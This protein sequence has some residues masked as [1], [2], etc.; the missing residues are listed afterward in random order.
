[1]ANWD[2]FH[3]DRL[4]LERNLTSEEIRQAV[5]KGD[6][7]DDDLVRPAGTTIAWARL[8]DYPDL[9]TASARLPEPPPAPV[10]IP[11]PVTDIPISLD[12]K[13][14]S[15]PPASARRPTAS[16][17]AGEADFEI[18]AED[19]LPPAGKILPP[20]TRA[21]GSSSAQTI[22]DD[23]SFPVFND[24]PPRSSSPAKITPPSAPPH[25]SRSS[26]NRIPE[27]EIPRADELEILDDDDEAESLAW[28]SPAV[29][30]PS[31][32]ARLA[33]PV[34]AARDWADTFDEEEPSDDDEED[35][36]LSRGGPM[37]VEELDLAPMVDVAFQLVLF[38]MVAAQ[39]VLYKTLEI[40][41]PSPE[42]PPSAVAQGRSRTL[43]DFKDDF[44][45][46]EI[47]AGGAMKIDREPVTANMETL[48]ELLRKSREK[49]GRQAM[50]LSADFNTRHR[51][52]VMAYDAANEVGLRIVIAR[53]AKPKPAGPSPFKPPA[54]AQD[55]T[56]AG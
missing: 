34:A 33:G 36:T 13:P 23:V 5:T 50:M 25:D 15:Q 44:I 43:D 45:L 48:V 42:T 39:T 40:P 18:I 31:V 37:T 20:N 28:P 8:G 30:P 24:A 26:S 47:D 53:P 27:Q 11:A 22:S 7:R 46:V 32:S 49:T 38:F 41:K 14:P 29:E 56:K 1:M 51:N 35:F 19:R 55:T 4:E 17:K 21:H 6:L 54:T 2:V 16:K 52:T 9:L 12:P 10:N 3:A